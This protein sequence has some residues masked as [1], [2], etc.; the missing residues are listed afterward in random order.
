MLS[1]KKKSG[2][3]SRGTETSMYHNLELREDDLNHNDKFKEKRLREKK[4]MNKLVLDLNINMFVNVIVQI[5]YKF[6]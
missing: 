3:I 5:N 4:L 6:D 2:M 1:E